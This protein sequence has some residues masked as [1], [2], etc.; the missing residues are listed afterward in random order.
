MTCTPAEAAATMTQMLDCVGCQLD[1]PRCPRHRM[2]LPVLACLILAGEPLQASQVA[3]SHGS[4]EA[5][6]AL[7]VPAE[8]AGR[9]PSSTADLWMAAAL[10]HDV[11]YA[12]PRSGN[13]AVDGARH[14]RGLGAPAPLVALVAWHSI[15]AY[16]TAVRDLD[17]DLL[18]EFG[19]PSELAAAAL[20][21]ADFTTS[22]HGRPVTVSERLTEIRSR[23]AADS[24]VLAALAAAEPDLA[25]ARALVARELV[26]AP[27]IYV[28]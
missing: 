22:P 20:W 3:H 21:V 28:A 9:I 4:G 26:A 12:H 7:V 24:P 27:H 14:L 8:R 15:S 6:R 2:S 5:M 1:A 13:H 19:Q 10:L 18:R 25:G 11:G 23:Y 17:I 16:E